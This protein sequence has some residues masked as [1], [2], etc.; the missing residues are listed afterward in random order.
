MN[1]SSSSRNYQALWRF[2]FSL[3]MYLCSSL[4]WAAFMSAIRYLSTTS[5]WL[6][7]LMRFKVS[8]NSDLLSWAYFAWTASTGARS[9]ALSFVNWSFNAFSLFF[10]AFCNFLLIFLSKFIRAFFS[11]KSSIIIL[12][13]LVFFIVAFILSSSNIRPNGIA[14]LCSNVEPERSSRFLPLGLASVTYCEFFF[15]EGPRGLFFPRV[16]DWASW[17]SVRKKLP[18]GWPSVIL[19]KTV[20]ECRVVFG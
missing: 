6:V 19:G 5:F 10:S 4:F 11:W 15:F 7:S 14:L 8:L 3:L 20:P 12:Y 2:S 9:L 16:A 1:L 18:V 13:D 17:T